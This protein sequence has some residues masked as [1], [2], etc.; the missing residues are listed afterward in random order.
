MLS[1]LQVNSGTSL[2]R[3]TEWNKSKLFEPINFRGTLP[4]S[5]HGGKQL[6]LQQSLAELPTGPAL[7]HRVPMWP[8][9]T[10]HANPNGCSRLYRGKLMGIFCILSS[11]RNTTTWHHM[12]QCTKPKRRL[13]NVNT[14]IFVW[15]SFIK[16]FKV[17]QVWGPVEQAG[18]DMRW[19]TGENEIQKWKGTFFKV[20][21]PRK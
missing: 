14:V 6:L 12:A 15:T 8:P 20:A 13:G 1:L 11:L 18:A 2:P 10:R 9:V 16:A 3:W 5:S 19:N 7:F 4:R 21:G 17:M